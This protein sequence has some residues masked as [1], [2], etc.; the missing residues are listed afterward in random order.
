MMAVLA[1]VILAACLGI[2]ASYLGWSFLTA[3]V[4]AGE[5]APCPGC[6]VDSYFSQGPLSPYGDAI[7]LHRYLCSENRKALAD[8]ADRF[9]TTYKAALAKWN[10]TPRVEVG[11]IDD[12]VTND[13]GTLTAPA[14]H[15]HEKPGGIVA[16]T[17]EHVWLFEVVKN[18]DGW[19]ICK[20]THPDVCRDLVRCD[21]PPPAYPSA[22]SK[23]DLSSRQVSPAR[24]IISATSDRASDSEVKSRPHGSRPSSRTPS[25]AS[26]RHAVPL[27]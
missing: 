18:N 12:Q 4:E 15:T 9:A 25:R 16:S 17:S 26:T 6:A 24:V 3:T 10:L 7:A 23:P 19:R 5:G 22:S 14:T 2:P 11:A 1:A 20:V 21:G 27:V 8:Q 13:R